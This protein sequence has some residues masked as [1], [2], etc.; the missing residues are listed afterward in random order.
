[1]RRMLRML[2]MLSML[3]RHLGMLG[4]M[5]L[6][7]L[8]LLHLLLSLVLRLM[9]LLRLLLRLGLLVGIRGQSLSSRGGRGSG[10]GCRLLGLGLCL[11][12]WSMAYRLLL[13]RLLDER[14]MRLLLLLGGLLHLLRL[15]GLLLLLGGAGI[16]EVQL[17]RWRL[18]LLV[19]RLAVV[20][21][22]IPSGVV[23]ERCLRGLL[24][25]RRHGRRRLL[26]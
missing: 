19:A 23:S 5:G 12:L 21:V 20:L 11:C 22:A 6:V 10:L 14:S 18:L 4:S 3:R 26:P 8:M 24:L 15:R 16:S 1:M 17:R 25:Q 13:L 2:W 9:L 7:D